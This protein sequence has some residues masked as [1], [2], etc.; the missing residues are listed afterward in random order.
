MTDFLRGVSLNL[1]FT[2]QRYGKKMRYPN[3]ETLFNRFE[4]FFNR[5]GL[6]LPDIFC[7]FLRSYA[8]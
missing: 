2:V 8:Y 6:V 3:F 7:M 5:K 1:F 4:S